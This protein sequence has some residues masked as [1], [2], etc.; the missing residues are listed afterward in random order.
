MQERRRHIRVESPVLVE[1]PHPET[2]KTE[3]S[4][5]SDI[6]ETGM[7]FPTT[8]KLTVSQEIVLT[9][10]LP[11]LNEPMHA[12][13]QVMWVREISRLGAPQY[14]IGIR[15]QWVDDPDRHRLMNHLTTFFPGRK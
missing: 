10:Q 8:V 12:T 13:G 6:S 9:L 7:R 5:T 1:F 15:F 14:E 3:R 2:M 4:F 11:F